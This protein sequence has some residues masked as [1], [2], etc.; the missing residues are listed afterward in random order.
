MKDP[1]G[2]I[3]QSAVDQITSHMEVNVNPML[4]EDPEEDSET[5]LDY[6][7]SIEYTFDKPNPTVYVPNWGH[8]DI[9]K[10]DLNEEG[11][12][13]NVLSSLL[14]T[15]SILNLEVTYLEAAPLDMNTANWGQAPP[16]LPS[17]QEK[18]IKLKDLIKDIH[19][20]WS[21][22]IEDVNKELT[23]AIENPEQFKRRLERDEDHPCTLREL[24]TSKIPNSVVL[25]TLLI[26]SIRPIQVDSQT[27]ESYSPKT[28]ANSQEY[29]LTGEEIDISAEQVKS[30]IEL[31]SPGYLDWAQM[32]PSRVDVSSS[33]IRD[34]MV[35]EEEDIDIEVE[36]DVVIEDEESDKNIRLEEYVEIEEKVLAESAYLFGE[37]RITDPNLI[38][39][40]ELASDLVNEYFEEN[41]I[42]VVPMSSHMK[43]SEFMDWVTQLDNPMREKGFRYLEVMNYFSDDGVWLQPS[44]GIEGGGACDIATLIKRSI[45][46]NYEK[47]GITE[48]WFGHKVE[49]WGPFV[50]VYYNHTPYP[51]MAEDMITVSSI[52]GSQAYKD[53]SNTEMFIYMIDDHSSQFDTDSIRIDINIKE[54]GFYSQFI[55]V[56]G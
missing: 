31:H 42:E 48:S 11:S 41:R 19:P 10:P 8:I 9:S 50:I 24:I 34:R 36:Q 49:R 29:S 2:E 32:E 38:A 28:V 45:V 13:E 55:S 47:V 16:I 27:S 12:P 25:M 3:Y 54:D 44:Q 40:M 23:F 30:R 20:A 15:E 5:I 53:T 39:N 35:D 21:Q 14:I 7:Q 4:L 51:G 46:E 6:V 43:L 37:E 18:S 52:T 26:S 1:T 33:E 22:A 17:E 56:D